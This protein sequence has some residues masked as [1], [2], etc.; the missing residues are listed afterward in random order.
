MSGYSQPVA[1]RAAPS[2]AMHFFRPG[3]K[4]HPLAC[5]LQLALASGALSL[6]SWHP[7][8]HAQTINRASAQQ[9]N[10]RIPAG[11]LSTALA[12][13]A[14]ASGVLVAGAGELAK[15]RNSPGVSGTLSP[16]A[17]L[18]ALLAGTGLTAVA[19][20]DGS[21]HLRQVPEAPAGDVTQLST[22][23]VRGQLDPRTEGTGSYTNASASSA[24]RM[25]LSAR[26]T[27]QSVSVIT[28]QR[29]DD[30]GLL[31]LNDALKQATGVKVQEGEVLGTTYQI[32][33]FSLDTAQLDGVPVSLGAGGS[34][35]AADMAIYDRVEVVRGAAGLLQGAGNPGGTLNLV[36]KQPTREFAASG[37]AMVGSWNSYRVEADVSSPLN[38]SGDLRGRVVAV[39]DDRD[40]FV[41][42]VK[43]RKEVLYGVLQ[44]DFTPSITATVGVDHQRTKGTPNG[45]GVVFFDDGGDLELPRSTYLGADWNHRATRSTTVFGDLTWEMDN[46]WQTKLSANRQHYDV[47]TVFLSASGA[48]VDRNTH[49]GPLLNYA[50]ASS[51]N[52]TQTSV[53]LYASGPFSLLGRKHEL[54]VGA[55]MRRN[56][57]ET[58]QVPLREYASIRP[59]VFNW[60]PTSLP[61]PN[62][63][64]YESRTATTTK[65]S[66]IYTAARLSLADPLTLI[67]GGRW[68]WWD[69]SSDSTNLLTG[70]NTASSSYKVSGE[71][72]P[73]A[74]LIFDLNDN[75]SLYASYTDVFRPQNAIDRN[76][77]LLKP[78]VGANYEA[79]IKGEFQDGRVQASLAA[80]RIEE[81]N[82]AQTDLDGPKPCPYTTSD[83]CS[84]AAGK[85]RSEGIEAELTG[86]LAP[87][88]NL[89]AGYTYNTTKYVKDA[90]N[91][92]KPFNTRT[93]EHM[94]KLF[95][96]YRLPGSLRQ[97]TVGGGFTWQTKFLYENTAGTI[98]IEQNPYAV[99]DLMVRYDFTP[100]VSATLNVNNVFDKHYYRYIA[101]ERAYNYYGDPRNVML[102]L[103]AQY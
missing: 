85:V 28:R 70:A 49:L 98:R 52:R 75:Y 84:I 6:A 86:E 102:T 69:Y 93:P 42:H 35:A 40:S 24:T 91:Q 16:Q 39:H 63:G 51:L 82:R 61:P 57:T 8:A 96:S 90:A 13:F 32:R 89:T 17:A 45:T 12:R 76:G 59:D 7:Q 3:F 23:T 60:D 18:D 71:F 97:W 58:D 78:I 79:G 50:K 99:A 19:S 22:V 56:P 100:K 55:N 67:V 77:S 101:H 54:V 47:D 10:Y 4:L 68:S 14:S 43:E 21:Y 15:D 87:G 27:P 9:Q 41:D 88:W 38:H 26:E 31:T 46:G 94:F 80:F 11:P 2:G 83:Y 36:R 25:N 81:T 66:G 72:T 5:V 1:R 48:G 65:Q 62:I 20:S 64:P 29:L 92:G 37:S 74:G 34:E 95:T 73:Y 53:D 44:Y 33:G 103:R 30:Q